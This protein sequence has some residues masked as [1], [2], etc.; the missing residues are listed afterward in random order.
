MESR[1]PKHQWT[2]SGRINIG[3]EVY[4]VR[5]SEDFNM[6]ITSCWFTDAT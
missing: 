3:E 5:G 2:E 4:H 6:S 1:K